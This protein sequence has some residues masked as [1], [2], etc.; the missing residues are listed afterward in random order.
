LIEALPGFVFNGFLVRTA[1]SRYGSAS[2]RIVVR[3]S[4]VRF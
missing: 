3:D 1:A 4:V 2:S